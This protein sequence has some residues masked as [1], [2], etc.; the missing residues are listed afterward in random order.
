MLSKVLVIILLIVAL[1]TWMAVAVGALAFALYAALAPGLGQAGA[2]A[3]VAVVFV[4][5]ILLIAL[6]A[7]LAG[8]PKRR[9]DDAGLMD[10]LMEIA[11]EKPMLAVGAAIAAGILAIRNP[12]W[13]ATVVAAFMDQPRNKK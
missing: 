4:V 10:R 8:K 9:A 6:L 11:R 3:V 12:A 1:A 7:A 13:V 5:I 2:A